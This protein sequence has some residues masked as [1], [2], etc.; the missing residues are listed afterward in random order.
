[1]PSKNQDLLRK[2]RRE[3][4]HRNRAR[5]IEKASERNNRVRLELR[6][7]VLEAIKVGCCDC[8]EI[9]PVVLEFDHRDRA[10]KVASINHMLRDCVS[11]KTLRA[12][13]EKC[14]VRCANCHRRRHAEETGWWRFT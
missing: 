4:Y 2:L 9:D 5:Y 6:K 1:M 11:P 7:I 10:Q 13:I 14:D 12:E 8:P 3:H